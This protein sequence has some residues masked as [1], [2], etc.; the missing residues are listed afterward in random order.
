MAERGGFLTHCHAEFLSLP[1]ALVLPLICAVQ[2]GSPSACV[3]LKSHLVPF[4]CVCTFNEG[5][6]MAV[7]G[8]ARGTRL[9]PRWVALLLLMGADEIQVG[10][11]MLPQ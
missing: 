4:P 1:A 11:E 6:R 5:Q 7:G 8:G 2:S 9:T 3:F 10:P